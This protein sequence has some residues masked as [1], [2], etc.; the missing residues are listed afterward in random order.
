MHHY[1]ILN[2]YRH[3]NVDHGTD[4]DAVANPYMVCNVGFFSDNALLADAGRVM[5]VHV[6]PD[7]R[8]RANSDIIFNKGGRSNAYGHR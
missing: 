1:P 6:I 5:D 2:R 7:H 8:P 4:L 3:T